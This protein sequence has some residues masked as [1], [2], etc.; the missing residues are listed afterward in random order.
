MEILEGQEG[1]EGRLNLDGT[2]EK[3][4]NWFSERLYGS[5]NDSVYHQELEDFFT[6]ERETTV[7]GGGLERKIEFSIIDNLDKVD[8]RK[9][10]LGKKKIKKF[11][12]FGYAMA[13]FSHE[14]QLR[15]SRNPFIEHPEE[16]G[17]DTAKYEVSFTTVAGALLHDGTE[18]KTKEECERKS[19]KLTEIEEA[20][21]F[22][23]IGLEFYNFIRL[24]NEFSNEDKQKLYRVTHMLMHVLDGITDRGKTNDIDYM[25]DGIFYRPYSPVSKNSFLNI[26]PNKIVESLDDFH[27]VT[28]NHQLVEYYKK[29][30]HLIE[31]DKDEIEKVS[32]IIRNI[33]IPD[34]IHNTE[35]MRLLSMEFGLAEIFK[36]FIYIHEIGLAQQRIENK[37]FFERT[38]NQGAEL[39]TRSS[40][41]IDH[42]TYSLRPIVGED[43]MDFIQ[44]CYSHYTEMKIL[45]NPNTRENINFVFEEFKKAKELNR[46]VG[47][48][49]E[50]PEDYYEYGNTFDGF[51]IRQL[52]ALI[53]G[54]GNPY[55][56]FE[57]DNLELKRF[58]YSDFFFIGHN[59]NLLGEEYNINGKQQNIIGFG[60]DFLHRYPALKRMYFHPKQPKN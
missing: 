44:L 15:K 14:G 9:I 46:K 17:E 25:R 37:R 41:E 52:E 28:N 38:M 58:M 48:P 42:N 20:A 2:T 53:E 35:T 29:D 23:S 34:R 36:D 10:G 27:N 57:G 13:R 18:H 39:R 5:F 33:K 3:R 60:L 47:M 45:T 22:Y 59:I 21:I 16:V 31:L 26:D 8:L 11:L 55:E 12:K 30:I 7:F 50:L 4:I 40:E 19:R 51:L 24:D 32:R 56:N 43:W 54:N 49:I 1:L 6:R